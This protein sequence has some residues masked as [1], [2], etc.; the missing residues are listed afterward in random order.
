[1]I[2]PRVYPSVLGTSELNVQQNRL[3]RHLLS[4]W[5]IDTTVWSIDTTYV[6]ARKVYHP[7]KSDKHTGIANDCQ[8]LTQLL[9][10]YPFVR[11][12]VAKIYYFPTQGST[13]FFAPLLENSSATVESAA[14]HLGPVGV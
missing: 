14:H 5:S 9:Y 4:V 12:V 7:S 1:M 3:L 10:A 2:L 8:C 13:V 11:L 6:L